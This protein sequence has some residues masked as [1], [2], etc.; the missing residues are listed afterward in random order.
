MIKPEP[1]GA[2]IETYDSFSSKMTEASRT[3]Y[4]IEFQ[5]QEHD[6][7]FCDYRSDM[8]VEWE[9]GDKTRP[10]IFGYSYDY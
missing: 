3:M 6:S 2:G 8:E 7:E 10:G 4:L 1:D 5:L 9:A